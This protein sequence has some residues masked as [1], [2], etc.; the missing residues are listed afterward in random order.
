MNKLFIYFL[1]IESRLPDATSDDTFPTDVHCA[2]HW[3]RSKELLAREA[4][5]DTVLRNCLANLL[6]RAT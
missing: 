5:Q 4:C 6:P 1:R 2:V 3:C